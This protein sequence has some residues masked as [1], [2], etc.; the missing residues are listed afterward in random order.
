MAQKFIDI[1]TYKNYGGTGN[2][3]SPSTTFIGYPIAFAV[4]VY[5]P[6]QLSYRSP[7]AIKVQ[8]VFAFF[9]GLEMLA[10]DYCLDT[11]LCFLHRFGDIMY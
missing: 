6:T 1:Y 11:I 4:D 10:L 7:V 2:I 3:A 9:F 8:K 5:L